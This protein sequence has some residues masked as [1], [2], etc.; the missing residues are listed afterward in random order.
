MASMEA[1]GVSG[2]AVAPNHWSHATPMLLSKSMVRNAPTTKC[3]H[4]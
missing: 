4:G 1:N 2:S 3:P